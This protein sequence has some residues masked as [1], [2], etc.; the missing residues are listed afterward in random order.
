MKKEEYPLETYNF[1]VTQS[2]DQ[3]R[4]NVWRPVYKLANYEF[5]FGQGKVKE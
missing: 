3:R 2:V 5:M 1:Y 4:R